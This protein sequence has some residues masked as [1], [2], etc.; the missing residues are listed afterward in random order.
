MAVEKLETVFFQILKNGERY[1][2]MKRELQCLSS[3]YSNKSSPGQVLE[4]CNLIL[5]VWEEVFWS[6]ILKEFN[7]TSNWGTCI[8]QGSDWFWAMGKNGERKSAQSAGNVLFPC[9]R[10]YV[11]YLISY[12]TT[13]G[14]NN[15]QIGLLQSF[16]GFHPRLWGFVAQS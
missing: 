11:K 1:L 6:R 9:V 3:I 8:Y 13:K 12:C 16:K 14:K 15:A 10:Q 5:G 7:L 2:R 4:L